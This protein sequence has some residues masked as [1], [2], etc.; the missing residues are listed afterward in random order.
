MAQKNHDPFRPADTEEELLETED[1]FRARSGAGYREIEISE[2]DRQ[3]GAKLRTV[4]E[5]G[6]RSAGQQPAAGGLTLW[7]GLVALLALGSWETFAPFAHRAATPSSSDW[8]A[9]VAQLRTERDSEDA[10]ILIAPD[11]LAP[12]AR[13]HLGPL[14]PLAMATLSDVDRF[15][16]IFELSLKGHRHRWL[17]RRTA[18]KQ[19]DHGSLRL[20][21]FQQTAAQIR[22]DFTE[23]VAHASV[24]VGPPRTPCAKR[25]ERFVCNARAGWNWVGP[26]LAEVAHRPYRCVYAHPVQGK[27]LR[28]SF[29]RVPL[30]DQIIAY[31][32]IDDF[33][34]R[35]KAEGQVRLQ[36]FVGDRMAGAIVHQNSWPWHRV[37]IDTRPE[38]NRLATVYFEVTSDRGFAR[39][40]CFHA[41][42]RR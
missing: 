2:G 41:E 37:E 24:T 22:Y 23:K 30:G 19:F 3:A 17:Q 39:T 20:S 21:L 9:T 28:I 26:H 6:P 38:A 31:T 29:E 5:T 10:A 11:W 13:F 35:K 8:A 15:G 34:N 25:G 7:L 27:R 16:R 40:F 32:G 4:R 42:A 1:D 12:L 18:I 33:D 14:V 36:V